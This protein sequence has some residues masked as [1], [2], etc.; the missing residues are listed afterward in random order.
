MEDKKEKIASIGKRLRLLRAHADVTQAEAAEALGISQQSLSGI[1]N[2]VTKIDVTTLA[3]I[4]NYYGVSSDYILGLDDSTM[5]ATEAQR[6]SEM[7]IIKMLTDEK[8]K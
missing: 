8:N 2:G 5:R 1:E 7:R 4:C 6:V 3:N